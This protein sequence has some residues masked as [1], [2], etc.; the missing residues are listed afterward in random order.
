MVGCTIRDGGDDKLLEYFPQLGER[1]AGFEEISAGTLRKL[2]C[3]LNN[4]GRTRERIADIV[5]ELGY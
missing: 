5:E 4:A 3:T 2:V 1:V